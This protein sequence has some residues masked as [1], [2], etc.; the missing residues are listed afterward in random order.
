MLS[1]YSLIRTIYIY[2]APL[3]VKNSKAFSKN[4]HKKITSISLNIVIVG[5]KINNCEAVQKNVT[6]QLQVRHKANP[7]K[8]QSK[9]PLR[10]QMQV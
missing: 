10:C 7:P 4:I 3:L 1:L 9:K 5:M 8:T 6:Q 2:I